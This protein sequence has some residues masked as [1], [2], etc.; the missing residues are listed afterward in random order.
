MEIFFFTAGGFCE[1]EQSSQLL[2]PL[3]AVLGGALA[4]ELAGGPGLIL[5]VLTDVMG[6]GGLGAP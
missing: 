6:G 3:P 4:G 5:L 2:L 1:K